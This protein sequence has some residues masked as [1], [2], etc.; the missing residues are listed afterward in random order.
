MKNEIKQYIKD[1]G[2]FDII[3]DIHGCYNELIM[4]I[5]RLGYTKTKK[6]YVHP[7]GR[8]LISVGD[9]ADRGYNNIKS[10][11]VIMKMVEEK[12]AYYVYGNHCNKFYRYL[13]GRKVQKTHGLE[14]TVTEFERLDDKEVFRKRYISMYQNTF[15]YLILDEGRLVVSH[16]GIKEILIGKQDEQVKKF[17]L[18]GDIT[19]EFDEE[20]HPVRKDWFLNYAGKPMIVYGHTPMIEP[21]FINN[22]V[23][24]DTGCVFGGKLTALRYPEKNFVQVNSSM[25]K[26][27]ERILRMKKKMEQIQK[28]IGELNGIHLSTV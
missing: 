27:Q 16:A 18:Y 6:G 26:D 17:C 5:E 22:T 21:I 15:P 7:K 19:G 4:L 1:Q 2:P 20:G 25:K 28:K 13:I 8:K 3:G 10:I 11:E 14:D 12:N 23:D 9:L 24:I